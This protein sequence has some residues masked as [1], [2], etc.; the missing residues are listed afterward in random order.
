MFP[1]TSSLPFR[2]RSATRRGGRVPFHGQP[3]TCIPHP[4]SRISAASLPRSHFRVPTSRHGSILVVVLIICLGLVSLTLVFGHSM[5]MAY[6][7]ADNALAGRQADLA[8]EGASRY[9]IALM[10]N[11]TTPGDFPDPT[12]Y[13]SAAVPVGDAYFWFIGQPSASDP[14]DKPVFRLADEAGK[15]SLNRASLTM[16][17]NLPGMTADLAA[18]IPAWRSTAGTVGGVTLSSAPVKQ[19]PF[20]SM[21]ELAL[22]NGGTD[23]SMLYGLDVNL[24]HVIDP[25]EGSAN[26]TSL[27][28]AGIGTPTLGLLE[29]VTAFS[30]E[31][32]TMSDGTKRVNVTDAANPAL[33]LLLDRV[34]GA[35]YGA[36]VMGRIRAAGGRV[37]NVLDFYYKARLTADEFTKISPYLTISNGT[38]AVGMV[39]VNTANPTVLSC[40]PGIT[41]DL[42]TQIVSQREQLTTPWTDLGAV[43]TILGQANAAQAG[44]YLTT[45]TYQWSVDV[46]AVG[47]YGR[48]YRRARL[49]IDSST[50]TPQVV[51]RRDL[52][53]LGWALGADARQA[54]AQ[55]QPGAAAGGTPSL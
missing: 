26:A 4:A 14:A 44:R 35:G 51:Y 30:R 24:N 40:V 7:G 33:P 43:G 23:V 2:H 53:N 31:P 12:A 54:L 42:A 20:E 41:Y 32:N 34:L 47:R 45:R 15:L 3:A 1:L 46:A 48:G 39:N 13:Q 27:A 25:E 8:I 52:T 17:A 16:L 55:L 29:Y 5:L 9:A 10:R 18:A 11:V 21:E 37:N 28:A 38:Y 22:V 6:R 50:G 36:R 19:G 49:V